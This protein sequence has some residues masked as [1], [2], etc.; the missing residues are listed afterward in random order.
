MPDITFATYAARFQPWTSEA[1]AVFAPSEQLTD[2]RSLTKDFTGAN[3]V[4]ADI[5]PWLARAKPH[6]LGTSF[7]GWRKSA[8]RRLMAALSDQVTLD[9]GNPKYHFNGPPTRHIALTDD[10]LEAL[11][12]AIIAGTE[13]IFGAGLDTETRHLLFANEWTRSY[14]NSHDADFDKRTLESAQ[15]AYKAYVNSSSRETLKA[16]AELRKAVIDETQKIS[17]RAQDLASALW[18][19]LA[20]ASAPFV[21]KVFTDAANVAASA[22]AAGLA[23]VAA[24]FLIFF[25]RNAGLH[26]L[27]YC[28]R[29]I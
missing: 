25:F 29:I 11:A 6:R 22:V 16:L 7:D 4:P 27:L 3:A 5:R 21:L 8:L 12:P 1:V 2:P 23:F 9:Q 28:L 24:I 18:K 19:D 14:Q 26:K 15:A 10:E 20:I 17:Q 13:W